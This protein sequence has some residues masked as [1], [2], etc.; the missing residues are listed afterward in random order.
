[1]DSCDDAVALLLDTGHLTF[2]GGDP[3]RAATRHAARIAHVHCKDVRRAV[4][5][6]QPQPRLRASSTPCSTACSPCPG[7]GS[8]DYPAR[9]RADRAREVPRLAR[10]RGGAGPG[11][12]PSAAVRRTSATA[13]CAASRTPRPG[14]DASDSAAAASSARALAAALL[15]PFRAFAAAP[16][17]PAP[18][19]R[20]HGRRDHG[21]TR[22]R[23]GA[24]RAASSTWRSSTRPTQSSRQRGRARPVRATAASDYTVRITV[25]GLAPA[26]RYYYRLL[27]RRHP[28]PLPPDAVRDPHGACGRSAVPARLRFL[29]PPPARCGAADLP[30]D[31]R[32]GARRLLLARRQHLCRLRLG[33]GVRRGLPPPARDRL[34]AAAHA[35][36]SRSSRSGTTTTSGSTTRTGTNPAREASLAAFQN[37]W[38]NPSYGL[39]GLR[40]ASSSSTPT[41]ASIS[42][43]WT[44]ATT[45]RPTRM[46]DGPE[47][48]L[49]GK[50]QGEWLREALLGEPRAVQGARLRQRLVV[51]GRADGRHLGRLPD[52]AQRALRLHPRQ[53]ASRACSCISGD[54]HFG[55]VN[56]DS[57]V[58][59]TAATTSTTS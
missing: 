40:P 52:R 43:C 16:G 3:V 41:A 59:S 35:L 10:R 29:R 48:T 15:R 57:L 9:A 22:S 56:C 50:R 54:T 5:A 4:L 1:M 46:P 53:R 31:H 28:G 12:A 2:A 8:V 24:A 34:D 20:P 27:R 51:R 44:A 30:R 13:T 36:A 6:S 23:S 18:D 39:A 38:A 58:R 26:T 11:V 42:S 14:D 17:Y 45:A 7:D 21:R 55:E 19:G 33:V 32:R 49:L 47:K 25:A 37:Y